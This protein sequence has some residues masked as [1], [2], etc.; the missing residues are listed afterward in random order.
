M[1]SINLG[2]SVV[3]SV[4]DSNFYFTKK[5]IEKSN[6]ISRSLIFDFVWYNIHDFVEI[7]TF[8]PIKNHVR[9]AIKNIRESPRRPFIH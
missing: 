5:L 4:R 6:R 8:I 7:F 2:D 1:K 3:D 9:S